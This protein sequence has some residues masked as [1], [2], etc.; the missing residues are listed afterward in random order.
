MHFRKIV[1]LVL[2]EFVARTVGTNPRSV[3]KEEYER[4]LKTINCRSHVVIKMFNILFG[5]PPKSKAVR[6]FVEC[7]I[8]NYRILVGP[9]FKNSY[10]VVNKRFMFTDIDF[11]PYDIS[12]SDWEDL[13]NGDVNDVMNSHEDTI[14]DIRKV[15]MSTQVPRTQVLKGTK[16][17]YVNALQFKTSAL[18]PHLN[19]YG[20]NATNRKMQV[21]KLWPDP[22]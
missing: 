3:S 19:E 4:F 11:H 7:W 15:L 18:C 8:R 2:L 5:H 21:C 20:G 17:L 6:E 12:W 9:I 1:A 16:S 22:R 13:Q 10:P 14:S